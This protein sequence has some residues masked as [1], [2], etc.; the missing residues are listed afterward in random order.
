MCFDVDHVKIWVKYPFVDGAQPVSK[1]DTELLLN[2]TWRPQLS[3][4][5]AAG[6]PHVR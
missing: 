3:I 6:M 1:E 4:T 5:G 2:K